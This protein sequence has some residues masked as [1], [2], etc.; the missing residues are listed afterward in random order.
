MLRIF[1][2]YSH[3]T[4]NQELP[5]PLMIRLFALSD[6]AR[7]LSQ[8]VRAQIMLISQDAVYSLPKLS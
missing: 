7:M 5:K 3:Y 6:V 4:H 1:Y 2:I 8:V